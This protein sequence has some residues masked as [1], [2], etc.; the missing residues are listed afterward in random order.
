M[1]FSR[2]LI[3]RLPKVRGTYTEDAPLDRVTWFRV[4]GPAEVMYR[5][6]DLAD[7]EQFVV[8]KPVD[9]PMT[10]LGVGSNLLVRD[11][12]VPGVVVR[13]GREFAA[14]EVSGAEITV[15]AGA[16]CLNVAMAS[17][18][19]SITG[20]EFLS[21]IPGTVGGAL[22]MNA[23]AYGREMKDVVVGARALT[24]YGK[25]ERLSLA[26]LGFT[27]RG[28]KTPQDWVFLQATVRGEHGVQSDIQRRIQ[29]IQAARQATQPQRA[30]TGGSTFKNPPGQHAWELIDK[31]GCRGLTV[32]GAM[33][34]E[35]HCNFLLNT[36]TA[37]AA[38]IEELGET[39]RAR[40]MK[41]FGV[42]LEWEI[43]R[44][45]VPLE[46]PRVTESWS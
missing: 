37:T 2:G 27:Y 41:E 4:G 44:I 23:G 45:G 19:G 30:A 39:V 40:V 3:N 28:G 26:D 18:Q 14:I 43:K 21:G 7:L 11:G 32:G 33:V 29:Q 12:G 16:L 20:L 25:V 34:S 9:V 17:Q 6:A 15:G 8:R 10:M 42:E 24:P 46:T 13:L 36:G 31:A 1:A 22:R 35:K 38:D 5:P